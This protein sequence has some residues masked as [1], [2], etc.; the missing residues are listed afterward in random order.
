[1]S[2]TFIRAPV[3]IQ[4][5]F[6]EPVSIEKI[7]LDAKVNSQKSNGFIIS[8]SIEP[9][10]TFISD[11]LKFEKSFC[12]IAKIVNEKN[13]QISIYEFVKRGKDHQ[14]NENV[15]RCFFNTKSLN[16]LTQ[17]TALKITITRTLSSS[18][19][20]L[21]SAKI[22]G[23][24]INIKNMEKNSKEKESDEIKEKKIKVPEDFIDALTNEMMRMPVKLPSN[25]YIDQSTLDRYISERKKNNNSPNDPFTCIKFDSNYKPIFDEKLK[26][27]IDKFLFD[28]SG[29]VFEFDSDFKKNQISQNKSMKRNLECNKLATENC[30]RIKQDLKCDSCLNVKSEGKI[31]YKIETCNHVYCRFCLT[32]I[33]NNCL[34]CKKEFKNSDVINLERSFLK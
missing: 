8:S 34:I 16:Y 11:K 17:A 30:K 32:S 28:N 4:I 1:M 22:Y 20:C 10:S 25:K 15:N 18:S 12:Q 23:N 24:V 9:I 5:V 6:N 27:K 29:C 2:D 3:S 13:V 33:N 19:P 14:A 31:V 21:K 26:S 7:I